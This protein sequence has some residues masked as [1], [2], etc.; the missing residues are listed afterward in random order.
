ML[1][2][3]LL[4][5]L[6]G[7]IIAHIGLLLLWNE[8]RLLAEAR[9]AVAVVLVVVDRHLVGARLR[10]VLPQLFLRC[11]DQAEI[12]LSMLI[13][14]LR[15]DGIARRTRVPGKLHIFLR[16]MRCGAANLD[17]GTVGFKYPGHRILA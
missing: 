1:A 13:V 5:A 8:A 2:R 7:L 14:I 17:I 6:I 12:M 10:L 15:S 9:I 4:I 11:G 16:H 3:L